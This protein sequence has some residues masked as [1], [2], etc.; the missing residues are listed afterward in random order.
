MKKTEIRLSKFLS[1]ILRHRP[2]A[3]GLTLDG[4]GWADIDELISAAN[5]HGR[6][7]TRQDI[8]RVVATNDKQR[9]TIEG[10]RIR[11]N[12]GHSIPVD[13]G[14]QPV[15]PPHILYHGTADK[16]LSNIRQQGLRKRKRQHVHLSPDI[17]T[18][19]KVGRRHGNLVILQVDAEA[20]H[21]AGHQFFLSNNGVW[22]IDSV[23]AAYLIEKP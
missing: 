22:L 21:A 8:E 20:M 13:L 16:Y 12:Q 4:E 17:E 10:S 18:A 19:S 15:V 1:R 9:F 2:Q 14:L 3:L 5:E 6:S 23:P 7:L 11:A